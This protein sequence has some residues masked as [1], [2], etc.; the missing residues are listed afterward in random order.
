M[1]STIRRIF[2]DAGGECSG[3]GAHV[4]ATRVRLNLWQEVAIY[5]QKRP[6][7][8]IAVVPLTD[9][10]IL[11]AIADGGL[12]IVPLQK[13]GPRSA[14]GYSSKNKQSLRTQLCEISAGLVASSATPRD[15]W[16]WHCRGVASPPGEREIALVFG[17][18]AFDEGTS[19]L[20]PKLLNRASKAMADIRAYELQQEALQLMGEPVSTGPRVDSQLLSMLDLFPPGLVVNVT[21]VAD[22]EALIAKK[23]LNTPDARHPPPRDG[24]YTVAMA[25]GPAQSVLAWVTWKPHLGLPGYSEIRAATERGQPKAFASPRAAAVQHSDLDSEPSPFV[26]QVQTVGTF[27]PRDLKWLNAF[28]EDWKLGMG[29]A[30]AAPPA[31][32]KRGVSHVELVAWYAPHH[33]H[34]EEAWGIWV[35]AQ[36]LDALVLAVSGDLAREGL[37][38]VVVDALAAQMVVGFLQEREMFHA[39]CEAVLTWLELLAGGPKFVRYQERVLITGRH[40]GNAVQDALASFWA[41][42][43]LC[44]TSMMAEI[45]GPL[46]FEDRGVL[47]RTLEARFGLERSGALG[48][49]VAQWRLL[50]TQ[51]AQGRLRASSDGLGLPLE[52]ILRADAK[53]PFEFSGADVP[54]H[55]VGTGKVARDLADE[56]ARH[57]I[58]SRSEL[59]QAILNHFKCA[60]LPQSSQFTCE[61]FVGRAGRTFQL[62]RRTPLSATVFEEFLR[63][64]RLSAADYRDKVRPGLTPS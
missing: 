38:P 64:F 60:L 29:N 49:N 59:R 33:L 17:L 54:F 25:S 30:D 19:T 62:P 15:A 46:S 24:I 35:D 3:R 1:S 56:L 4:S 43:W 47:Q 32:A 12:E 22:A 40:A 41:W 39:R 6:D 26:Q 37:T 5:R 28:G 23:I 7:L 44:P 55:V 16:M 10:D 14:R 36:Q 31:H 18:S 11:P 13:A 34:A 63:H 51:M 9:P 52:G 61:V 57:G 2:I 48:R 42:S 27:D 50:A 58:P 8:F 20:P 53:L 45:A 21:G